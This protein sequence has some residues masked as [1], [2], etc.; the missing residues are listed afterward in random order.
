MDINIRYGSFGVCEVSCNQ[1]E[2]FMTDEDEKVEL[3]LILL[4]KAIELISNTTNNKN[5]L[6]Q[7]LLDV[8]RRELT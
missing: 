4:D 5:D 6:P 8:A 3:G 1:Q 2:I 7:E